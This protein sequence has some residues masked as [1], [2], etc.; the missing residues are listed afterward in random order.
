M[1]ESSSH[2]EGDLLLGPFFYLYADGF[3]F[4][5][6]SRRFLIDKEIL[7]KTK[8]YRFLRRVS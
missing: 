2:L 3:T 4:R 6:H 5:F 1:G 7:Q 8:P